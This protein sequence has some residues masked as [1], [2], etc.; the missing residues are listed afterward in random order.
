MRHRTRQLD[1]RHALA[2]YL[3]LC[4][5][6]AALFADDPPVLEALVFAAEALVVL[7]GPEYFR[8]EQPVTLRLECPVVDRLRLLD[9]AERP[10]P[11]HVRRRQADAD[12]V[13]ILD[14]CLLS[15]ESQ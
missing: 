6:D 8:A 4:H 12:R 3:G 2:A 5:L 15:E 1:M 10:G 11:D 13:E 14:R 9:L 7:G